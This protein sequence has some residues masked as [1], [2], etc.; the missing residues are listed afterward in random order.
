MGKNR[1]V[2]LDT[3]LWTESLRNLP[4]FINGVSSKLTVQEKAELGF[5]TEPQIFREMRS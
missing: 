3:Y 1:K 2:L 4:V 5:K